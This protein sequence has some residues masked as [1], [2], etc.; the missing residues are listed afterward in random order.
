M[1]HID[2]WYQ[3]EHQPF[4]G[5]DFS[6]L[7]GRMLEEQPPWSYMAR[8]AELLEAASSVLDMG[9]GGGERLLALRAHWP[10][11]V[12]ATEDY[13]PN[14]TLAQARLAPAGGQVIYAEQNETSP[15]PFADA[16]FDL[17]LNR[18]S[19]MNCRELA[20]VLAPGGTFYTEQVHGLWAED[21]IA[22]FGAKPQWP[23]ATP[24]TYVPQLER[25]GLRMENVSEWQGKLT[26]TDVGA[27]VY[28]LKAVP[29]LVPG[30]TVDTHL[31]V[32][33]TLQNRLDRG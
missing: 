7:D 23:H 33:Q 28:Y 3:Q 8:A 9:T 6:H 25:A 22:T 18:H 4:A 26:F 1:T 14:V 15:M 16:A 13:A 17:L 27:I 24:E 10:P 29:W 19:G 31:E 20:R 2:F 32:L 21:L 30:F 12:F 5:W 11:R